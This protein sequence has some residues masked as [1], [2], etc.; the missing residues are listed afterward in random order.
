MK[1]CKHLQRQAARFPCI[2]NERCEFWHD[3]VTSGARNTKAPMRSSKRL[4]YKNHWRESKLDT[5]PRKGIIIAG[6]QAIDFSDTET[7][8]IVSYQ[9][10]PLARSTRRIYVLASRANKCNAISIIAIVRL[11]CNRARYCT[12]CVLFAFRCRNFTIFSPLCLSASIV[13]PTKDVPWNVALWARRC[14][15]PSFLLHVPRRRNKTENK[16]PTV[17]FRVCT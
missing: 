7:E 11:L 8:F 5:D 12:S 2:I 6:Q 3:R 16:S 17:L 14:F 15:M 9:P 10:P 1:F 13:M 4:N